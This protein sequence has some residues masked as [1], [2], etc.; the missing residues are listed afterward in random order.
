MAESATRESSI[1]DYIED[2]KDLNISFDTLHLKEKVQFSE[3]SKGVTDGILLGDSF[4]QKYKGDL[5]ELVVQKTFTADEARRYMTN[6]WALSYDLYG[7]VEYWFLLLDLNHMYSAV[8]FTQKTI[9]VYDKSLPDVI[10]TI[11]AS[12]EDFINSNE[13]EI[14]GTYDTD[15]NESDD[16]GDI[17]E[18]DE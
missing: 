4:V 7:S 1:D 8:E 6:P 9:N 16:D 10:D 5:D 11:L 12:E 18:S 15:I 14:S 3:D 2:H 17:E 13:A